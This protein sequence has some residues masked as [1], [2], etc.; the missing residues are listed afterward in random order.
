MKI[1]FFIRLFI[2]PS[3]IS[4]FKKIELD[5]ICLQTLVSM[6]NTKIIE[7]KFFKYRLTKDNIWD[8]D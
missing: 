2:Y 6:R 8:E 4:N 7:E 3:Y 5:M 1:S